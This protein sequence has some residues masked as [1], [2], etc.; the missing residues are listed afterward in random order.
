MVTFEP[1]ENSTNPSVKVDRMLLHA[2]Q[3]L[4][5]S[6]MYYTN[7]GNAK[8]QPNCVNNDGAK[9][10]Q[11][12]IVTTT[13]KIMAP[14]SKMF[15]SKKNWETGKF[16]LSALFRDIYCRWQVRELLHT[17]LPTAKERI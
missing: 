15:C 8:S 12:P 14:I 4:T 2:Q 11:I 1:L 16:N 13:V 5:R 3:R 17:Q 7:I 9:A 10:P 6:P